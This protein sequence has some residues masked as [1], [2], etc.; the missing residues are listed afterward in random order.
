MDSASEEV[1][2]MSWDEVL[3]AHTSVLSITCQYWSELSLLRMAPGPASMGSGC[4]VC[5]GQPGWTGNIGIVAVL[6]YPR[7]V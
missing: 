7:F 1:I 4:G 6:H 5:N 2:A 3:K